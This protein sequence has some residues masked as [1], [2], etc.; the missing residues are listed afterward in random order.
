MKSTV[1]L[2]FSL[3]SLA[4]SAQTGLIKG[5]VTDAVTNDA[6]E[7]ANV[8]IVG[9]SRG[10]ITDTEG[11]FEISVEPGFY[12]IQVSFLG[13]RT[14]QES[15]IEVTSSRP[16]VVDFQLEPSSQDLEEIVVKAE[17]FR[18]KA[19]SPLS[20][21]NIG[22]TEIKRNPGGNRGYQNKA[23]RRP[24]AGYREGEF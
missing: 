13:Y 15:E 23:G 9:S 24:A 10:A 8:L 11:K 2:L 22:I 5:Q 17:A 4:L 20:L 1:I 14:K 21:R 19:E 12:S 6:I 18:Q 16:V 7:F 3:L